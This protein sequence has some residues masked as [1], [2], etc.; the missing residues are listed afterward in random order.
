MSTTAYQT[1][2]DRDNPDEIETNGSYRC[3]S[4]NAWLGIGYYFWD[5]NA[6]WANEWG[7]KSYSNS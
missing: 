3:R 1:L 5:S 2:E 7:E 4:S 6:Q